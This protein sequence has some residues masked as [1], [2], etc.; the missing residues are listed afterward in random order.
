MIDIDLTLIG[1]FQLTVAGEPVRL[2]KKAQALLAYLAISGGRPVNRETL[3][4]LLW[5]DRQDQQ[6]RQSLRQAIASIRKAADRDDIEFLIADGDTLQLDLSRVTA[7]FIEFKQC[8]ENKSNVQYEAASRLTGTLLEEIGTVS[9]SFDT[10]L[11]RERHAFLAQAAALLETCSLSDAVWLKTPAAATAAQALLG[12]DPLCEP[13]H[14]VVIRH[15]MTN[16]QS[17]AAQRHFRAFAEKLR[18]ELDAEPEPETR[19]ALEMRASGTQPAAAPQSA[20]AMTAAAPRVARPALHIWGL[21]SAAALILMLGIFALTRL[22]ILTMSA[23]QTE[24][25]NEIAPLAANSIVIEPFTAISPDA[26]TDVFAIGL[27]DGLSTAMSMVSDFVVFSAPIGQTEDRSEAPAPQARYRL[28]GT[29]QL[30]GDRVKVSAKLT[31]TQQQSVMWSHLFERPMVDIIDVQNEIALALMTELRSELLEGEQALIR[32]ARQTENLE[33][34][35]LAAQ[36]LKSIK[37]LSPEGVDKALILYRRALDLDPDYSSAQ[38]GLAWAHTVDLLFGWSD[39]PEESLNIISQTSADLIDQAPQ[40]GI[41][42]CLRAFADLMAGRHNQAVNNARHA[43][44]LTPAAADLNA[45]YAFILTYVSTDSDAVDY[46]Q[47]AIDLSP[48]RHPWYA[49]NLARAY[50]LSGKPER[51]LNILRPDT[52]SA[53]SS[54]ISQVELISTY[55]AL[56]RDADAR[57]IVS[58][59]TRSLPNFSVGKWL[60]TPPYADPRVA[61]KERDLLIRAGLPQ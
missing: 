47:R 46:A 16:G 37:T 50:R 44:V 42:Y 45:L 4:A 17:G 41:G 49:W 24:P 18:E 10:W 54:P 43:V 30:A 40:I 21:A 9:E 20:P 38:S 39:T 22:P 57:A 7:D 19:Q 15:Y 29:V 58:D 11:D 5:D 34:W 3:S 25:G 31:D 59:I 32:P 48:V 55:M 2:G 60:E 61:K 26:S 36:A 12:R 6:A 27:S 51:A 52:D 56:G 33:A 8:L 23:Q 14:R 13:A 53:P 28:N 35:L 1:G